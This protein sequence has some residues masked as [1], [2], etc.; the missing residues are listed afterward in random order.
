[1]GFPFF[2]VQATQECSVVRLHSDD[3]TNRLTRAC[4]A[5]LIDGLGRLALEKRP[6][7][8]AGNGRFFSAGAD[9]QEIAALDGPS[10]YEFS[11]MGQ[12]LMHI[13]DCPGIC[14]NLGIL[15]GWRP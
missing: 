13:L 6:A 2:T 3:G 12:T 15:H 11:R 10:A 1:M 14:R 9:L 5:A 7:A 8:I 4:V